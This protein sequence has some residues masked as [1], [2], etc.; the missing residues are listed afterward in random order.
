MIQV[1]KTQTYR[2]EGKQNGAEAQAQA[3]SLLTQFP[4]RHNRVIISKCSN[5]KGLRSPGI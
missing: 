4:W 5:I 3:V 2:A 1:S